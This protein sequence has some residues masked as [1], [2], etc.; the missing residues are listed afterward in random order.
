MSLLTGLISYWELNETSGSRVDAHGS[1]DLTDNATVGSATGVQ[2]NAAVFVEA[3]TEYLS[4]AQASCVDLDGMTDLSIALWYNPTSFPQNAGGEYYHNIV[5][6]W[7]VASN[8]AYL[9]R[10]QNETGTPQLELA[11]T[12]DGTNVDAAAFY[13]PGFSLATWYHIAFTYDSSAAEVKWY[14][15]GTLQETDS[16]GGSSIASG[17][18]DFRIGGFTASVATDAKMDE[19]GIWSKV[20]TADEISTLYNSG[21]GLAYADLATA[22]GATFIPKVMFF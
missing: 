12:N 7:Y 13:T 16:T 21:S 10:Y 11:T 22:G 20:L 14:K 6:K 5:E 2:G 19:V 9:F 8:R 15:N 4:R 3:N 18:S 17:T 1:N